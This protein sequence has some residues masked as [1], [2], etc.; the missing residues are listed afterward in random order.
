M[1]RK[2]RYSLMAVLAGAA[3]AGSC[4]GGQRSASPQ[5]IEELRAQLQETQDSLDIFKSK[6]KK[7][8]KHTGPDVP[9]PSFYEYVDSLALLTCELRNKVQGPKPSGYGICNDPVR[10]DKVPPPTYPPR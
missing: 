1:T 9:S 10:V 3:V 7:Y 6:V 8:F 2:G 5:E 4:R